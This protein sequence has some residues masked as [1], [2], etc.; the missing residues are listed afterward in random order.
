MKKFS[1]K[2]LSGYIKNHF[3]EEEYYDYMMNVTEYIYTIRIPAVVTKME[4][5][6]EDGEILRE[7]R[8][9]APQEDRVKLDILKFGFKSNRKLQDKEVV[10]KFMKTFE[11][12]EKKGYAVGFEEPLDESE[13]T[14][15]IR[16]TYIKEF[17]PVDTTKTSRCYIP[18][19]IKG[20]RK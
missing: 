6:T 1:K 8:Y 20:E 17:I 12:V 18:V 13:D 3:K 19:H 7:E 4:V 11:D 9:S 16:R 2:D 5:I 15:L 10:D 14:I